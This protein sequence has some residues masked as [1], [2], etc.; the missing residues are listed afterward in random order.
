MTTEEKIHVLLIHQAFV[1]LDEAGGTRH[2][3]FA[4]YLVD[5]GHKV[6]VI[7]SRVSY[8]TGEEISRI[9]K[10]FEHID[11]LEIVRVSTIRGFHKSFFQRLLSFFSFTI[12]S[13]FA[14]MRVKN[15][16]LVWG[17]SPPLF[18]AFTAW[19][20][21]R[22]KCV[23]FLFEVRDLWPAFAV[24]VGVLRNRTLIAASEWLERFLYKRA[25]RLV[26]NSPGF[27]EHVRMRGGR[28][29]RI[30]PNGSDASMFDP[31]A[32]GTSFRKQFALEDKFVVL[33]AGAHGLSNDLSVVL[34]A[35]DE[36]SNESKISIVL[37]GDGKDKPKLMEEAANLKLANVHFLPP[38]PKAQM[39]EALASSDAC[40]AI[41]KPLK[42]YAT[43]YPNKIFDY[44]AAG[45]PVLL[46]IDGVIRGVVEEA[47]AGIFVEPGK[48]SA[49]AA[50]I[51]K[52]M[53]NPA[54]G[55]RMGLAGRKFL[56]AHFDR[57][58]LAKA[59]QEIL[60]DTARL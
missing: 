21:A 42:L 43:V 56:E 49:L 13:F 29:I 5:N 34:R 14:G 27:E 24:E 30:V 32:S 33:Y 37:L 53:G 10:N 39:A 50:A 16:N 17:T 44:M 18:Q 38:M 15:V 35:A 8:L 60:L 40:L 46:M 9:E 26:L 1:S 28:D 12:S 22:V 48:P 59:M 25:D 55:K 41:L 4:R 51:R 23:P 11:N 19:G 52:M 36:L 47:N 58:Q 54:E 7:T 57:S 6:T 3:E 45:R 20:L 31:Q 2:Y